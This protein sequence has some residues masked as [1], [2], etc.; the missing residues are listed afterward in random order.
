MNIHPG[1][2]QTS[3]IEII[4]LLSDNGG[5]INQTVISHVGNRHGND[6]DLTLELAETGCYIEYDSSG[7]ARAHRVNHQLH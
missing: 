5:N 7:K 2:S 4:E 3:P 6:I 1:Q